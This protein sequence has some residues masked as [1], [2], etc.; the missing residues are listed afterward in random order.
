MFIY[1]KLLLTALFWGGTFIAARAVA[2]NV[3]PFSAAF[4]RFII[5]SV[6]L[7]L[8]T[9]KVEGRLPKI[10]RRQFISVIL[11]G[12]TGVFAYNVFFFKGLKIINAGRAALIVATIPIFITIFSWCFFREKL[13]LIKV[14]GIITS[15]IGVVIV[16]SGGNPAG[17]LDGWTCRPSGGPGERPP[18][19]P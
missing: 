12:M 11:L 1:L 16:I 10:K 19:H 5:A 13:N 18:S 6:F 2:K 9:L 14:A 3:G 15:V 7:L 8:L 4:L 17:I